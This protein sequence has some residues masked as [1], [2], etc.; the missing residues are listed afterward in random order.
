MWNNLQ[1][2]LSFKVITFGKLLMSHQSTIFSNRWR[3]SRQPFKGIEL[4]MLTPWTNINP[5][6][7][8]Q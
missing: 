6:Q 5:D 4:I 1:D 7:A 8:L 3:T 2:I